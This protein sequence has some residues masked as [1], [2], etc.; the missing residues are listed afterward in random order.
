MI[1]RARFSLVDPSKRL[2]RLPVIS[3]R[4][5]A[6]WDIQRRI[7]G[8]YSNVRVSA[9]VSVHNMSFIRT[10]FIKRDSP[11]FLN[12]SQRFSKFLNILRT[13]NDCQRRESLKSIRKRKIISEVKR[14]EDDE[15]DSRPHTVRESPT[16][17]FQ[18]FW[19]VFQ[20]SHLKCIDLHHN[21][22]STLSILS[23]HILP[24]S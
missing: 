1:R 9:L 20:V 11:T 13:K 23:N 7:F 22:N 6:I 3:V 19:R 4:S 24:L 16:V 10:S 8:E 12:V 17:P 21:G 5:L 2:S 15:I 18:F 14:L